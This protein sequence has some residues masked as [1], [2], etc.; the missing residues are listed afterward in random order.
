MV[1]TAAAGLVVA[2]VGT[3]LAWQ[4]VGQ[5]GGA[6][7]KYLAITDE[8]VAT[9]EDT[10]V[11]ADQV[12]DD[13]GTALD[14]LDDVLVELG[15]AAHD[16]D[17][18]L[19]DVEALTADAPVALGEFQDTL[20]RVAGAAGDV[21][22]ILVELARLPFAPSYDPETNLSAQLEQLS[23]DLDP[24]IDTL[25]GSGDDIAS[26]RMTTSELGVELGGLTSDV[27]ALVSR[28]DES[29]ELVSRYRDQAGR[30]GDLVVDSR[31]DLDGSVT[32]IRVLVIL[33]GL[34]FAAGQLVP[35]WIGS[36]LLTSGA[37]PEDV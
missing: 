9:I 33:A 31:D 23:D 20:D 36:R 7:E 2:V 17:S 6:V 5:V 18:V 37:A 19:A 10:I 15:D 11:M 30:A 12:V 22:S 24:V 29:A 27:R 8:S 3:V 32:A 34:V 21:D 13:L 25:S 4:L 35:A 1:A 28:M 14:A 16:V 26:L